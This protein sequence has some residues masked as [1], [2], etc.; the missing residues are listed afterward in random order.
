[1]TTPDTPRAAAETPA[2]RT[3]AEI[4]D[5]CVRGGL[6]RDTAERLVR[7]ECGIRPLGGEAEPYTTHELKLWRMYA[8]EIDSGVK[9]FEFRKDDRTP[10]F[11]AGDI[12]RLREWGGATMDYSGREWLRRVTY[13]ARGGVIPEGYCCMAIEPL[14]SRA[15][16]SGGTETGEDTATENA[17][18]SGRLLHETGEDGLLEWWVKPE[19]TSTTVPTIGP[20]TFREAVACIAA[21]STQGDAV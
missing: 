1:M 17:V 8:D 9:T 19:R 5:G 12:L 6:P 15:A 2:G 20:M 7:Q 16:L 11:H 4:V 10:R 13:I 14:E 21:R 3:F 18:A